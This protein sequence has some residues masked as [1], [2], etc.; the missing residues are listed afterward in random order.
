MG[1]RR[2][3]PATPRYGGSASSS[4]AAARGG[5]RP[6]LSRVGIT[7]DRYHE[8]LDPRKSGYSPR[9][10]ADFAPPP[11][12]IRELCDACIAY[13]TRALAVELDYTPDTLPILD[14]YLREVP[15]E[16]SE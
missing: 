12:P 5:S 3:R 7:P 2:V 14:H 13:V 16:T 15:P 1:S 4:R 10:M 6:A 11:E 8:R 9:P